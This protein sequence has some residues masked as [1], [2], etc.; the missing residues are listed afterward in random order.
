MS[1]IVILL[2]FISILVLKWKEVAQWI[3]FQYKASLIPAYH[4]R[5]L[6]IFGHAYM[7]PKEPAKFF[8]A[9]LQILSEEQK[10]GKLF[11]CLR[12]GWLPI[13]IL[14]HPKSVEVV[15]RSSKLITKGFRY[16]Y[17]EPWLGTGLLTANGSKWKSHRR[18]LTPTFHFNILKTYLVVMNEHSNKL[19]KALQNQISQGSVNVA[20]AMTLCALDVICETAMGESV[21]ALEGENSEYVQA[22]NEYVTILWCRHN[23]LIDFYFKGYLRLF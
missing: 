18:L 7:F 8:K 23:H 21:K 15:L 19:I 1:L 20:Q 16:K 17:V 3:R 5:P 4:K 10:K 12:N 13:V 2:F 22:V 6:P 14:H 11:T 9:Y